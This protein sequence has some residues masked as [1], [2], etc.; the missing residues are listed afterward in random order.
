MTAAA[1]QPRDADLLFGQ[2]ASSLGSIG[3]PTVITTM[4]AA[5]PGISDLI[6]SPARPPQVEQHGELTPVSIPDLPVL[7]G[8]D[9]AQLARDLIGAN[10][11]T[12]RT[13]K[14]QG[15]CDFSY[16]LPGHARFRVNV[17]RQRGS[18]AAVMRVIPTRIPSLGELNLPGTLAEIASVKNGIVLVTGPTGSGKSST[19]AAMI[20]PDQRDARRAHRHHRRPNRVPPLSQESHRPSAR[21]AQ[22]HADLRARP[23]GGPAS[24]SQG[25]SGGRDARS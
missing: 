18:Y 21:V 14:E 7:R 1:P 6:F 4:L 5:G 24:G 2:S 16:A 25:H 12:L 10:E 8:E 22:R 15:A 13:L 17:F 11:F 19:L 23:Q 3:A 20:K 9:T